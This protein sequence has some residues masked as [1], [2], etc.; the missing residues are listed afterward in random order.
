M[1]A[2]E[3]DELTGL[4]APDAPEPD[5]LGSPDADPGGAGRTHG[6]DAMPGIPAEGEEPPSDG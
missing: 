4:P 6:E 1:A 3:P 2:E 5:P